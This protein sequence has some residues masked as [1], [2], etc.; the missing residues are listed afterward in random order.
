MKPAA[1]H[2]EAPATL[3]EALRL[4]RENADDGKILA[5]GQSLVPAMNFRLARP[6]VLVDINGVKE[7]DFLR[8]T[9]NELI[10]GALTRHAA[11]HKPVCG[12]PLGVM[13]AKVVR[14]IA[15]YPIRQRGT[16]GGSLCHAD[17]AS[18]WCLLAATLGATMV[19]QNQDGAREVPAAEYF[20]GTFTTAVGADEILAEIRLPKF[21]PGWGTGFY[22]FSRRKGDFALAMSLAALRIEGGVIRE[23]R[24]GL[25]AVADHGK[26]LVEL[27]AEL[28][29][30]E[31]TRETFVN[32][33]QRAKG[34]VN[35]S[36]DIH[37]SAEYRRDLAGTVIE[38]ALTEAAAEAV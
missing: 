24:L 3:A 2:Y 5:G 32:I 11:F 22:E 27:E 25:G 37:G 28:V 31:P 10:I 19:I 7:I 16:F 29:G 12:G 17:P 6:G 13:M 26:R 4:I 30:K 34:M 14:N 36:G 21:A 9:E 23:A 15:H 35:P 1:F 33:G 20:R 18:E 8:E 38:R